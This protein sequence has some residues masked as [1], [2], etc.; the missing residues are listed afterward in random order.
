ML[1]FVF[2]LSSILLFSLTCAVLFWYY[3]FSKK[4]QKW[5]EVIKKS[6]TALD[7][8]EKNV[9]E[10]FFACRKRF[11]I[12]FVSVCVFQ[13]SFNSMI[14]DNKYNFVSMMAL[15]QLCVSVF[16]L[17]ELSKDFVKF[18]Y[19]MDAFTE[20]NIQK[21]YMFKDDIVLDAYDKA[22][23]RQQSKKEEAKASKFKVIR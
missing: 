23:L 20:L 21:R 16:L 13:V 22:V 2:L 7:K 15:L 12:Y 9:I 6:K 18:Q 11:W 4:C 1:F 5:I 8:E 14:G 19:V 3:F 10:S 17:C